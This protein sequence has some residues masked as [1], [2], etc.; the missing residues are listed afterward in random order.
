MSQPTAAFLIEMEDADASP[1]SPEEWPAASDAPSQPEP[2][3]HRVKSTEQGVRASPPLST[4]GL[5][6]APAASPMPL[7][8]PAKIFASWAL[9]LPKSRHRE[10][11][12]A[13]PLRQPGRSHRVIKWSVGAKEQSEEH[14]RLS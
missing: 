1:A 5:R 12:D 10:T 7:R 9:L 13:L 8:S 3:Y 4:V 14:T 11:G 6:S 2:R